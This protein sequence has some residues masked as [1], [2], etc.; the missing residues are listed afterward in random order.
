MRAASAEL[1]EAYAFDV[2]CARADDRTNA[3]AR[4]ATAAAAPRLR[5]ISTRH[6]RRRRC[7]VEYP[8]G[9]P[10][11]RGISTRHPRRRRGSAD[12]P[13]LSRGGAAALTE[14]PRGTRGAAATRPHGTSARRRVVARQVD[15]YNR[16]KC[17]HPHDQRLDPFGV[18]ACCADGSIVEGV[19]V[20][21][22]VV[23][24]LA[25][26]GRDE[27][28]LFVVGPHFCAARRW[29]DRAPALDAP[30]PGGDVAIRA[31]RGLEASLY[32]SER[33][34]PPPVGDGPLVALGGRV[35]ALLADTDA[36]YVEVR[37]AASRWLAAAPSADDAL[38]CVD[39]R[40][41]TLLHAAVTR[42]DSLLCAQLAAVGGGALVSALDDEYNTPVHVAALYGRTL[43]LEKLLPF[44]TPALL[45]E[46]NKL[47]MSPLQL[48]CCDDA[49]GSPAAAALLVKAG[50]DVNAR[51][52]DK[53]PLM[54]AAA[55]EHAELVEELVM[56]LGADPMIRNGE[57][58]MAADYCRVVSTSEFLFGVMEGRFMSEKA[59]P[60]FVREDRGDDDGG[61][62]CAGWR[63]NV[64]VPS[65]SAEHAEY[66]VDLPRGPL[67][68]STRHPRRRFPRN[69][70]VAAAAVPRPVREMSARRTRVVGCRAGSARSAGRATCRWPTL[71]LPSRSART[72]WTR[73]SGT[74]TTRRPCVRRGG[75]SC[76]FI[77]RTS[78]P[79]T[80]TRGRRCGG[81]SGT[82]SFTRCS[83]R[84]RLVRRI[85]RGSTS[86]ATS[87]TRSRGRVKCVCLRQLR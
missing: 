41:R 14:Y 7:S 33:Y 55:C 22:D 42:G 2:T 46:R 63:P 19:A 44:A 5:G 81:R 74:A 64:T 16:K 37:A 78:G 56:E 59:A 25:E 17:R 48:C 66:A 9:S 58:H 62:C 8:R 4:R 3:E 57:M 79:R 32:A 45:N 10:R 84:T 18:R 24:K 87:G 26:E 61:G 67:G 65:R 34:A 1:L 50:A 28:E 68:L 54:C 12:Y 80:T 60:S 43:A 27:A 70:H 40:G 35:H 85:W 38:A 20:V 21:G 76:F 39:E 71:W 51:C 13:R 86:G 49:P 72:S 31:P 53:T 69:I 30:P 52:W 36:S 75:A 15:A 47:L 73:S 29:A 23:R 11:L 6:P 83:G 77:I 82:A